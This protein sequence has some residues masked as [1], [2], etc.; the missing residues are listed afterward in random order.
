MKVVMKIDVFTDPMTSHTS[1]NDSP[2]IKSSFLSDESLKPNEVWD[3]T[4]NIP[5]STTKCITKSQFSSICPT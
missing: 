5:Q 1:A 4:I 3:L 2:E